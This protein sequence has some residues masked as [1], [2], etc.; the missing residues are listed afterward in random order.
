MFR[1][2]IVVSHSAGLDNGSLENS[3]YTWSEIIRSKF[4][5][6]ACTDFL[7]NKFFKCICT[8]TALFKHGISCTVFIFKKSEKNMFTAYISVSHILSGLNSKI[9]CIIS[10]F[11]KT[12]EFIHNTYPF[13][14][15]V[16][17]AVYNVQ[18]IMHDYFLFSDN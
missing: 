9:D 8:C 2:N 5:L 3:L 18:C 16:Q 12:I 14:Y 10:L 4:S 13:L 15:N 1:A 11:C 7:F 17:C 6:T